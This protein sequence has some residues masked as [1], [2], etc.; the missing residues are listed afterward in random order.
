MNLRQ[1]DTVNVFFILVLAPLFLQNITLLGLGSAGLKVFHLSVA[2]LGAYWLYGLKLNTQLVPALWLLSLW[3]VITFI[4]GLRYGLSPFVLNYIFIFALALVISTQSEMIS[5]HSF[6]KSL[7]WI[8]FPAFLYVFFNILFNLDTVIAAQ[9]FNIRFGGRPIIPNMLFSG[10]WNIEASYLAMLSVLFIRTRWFF[11]FASIAFI[12]SIAYLSRT[13]LVLTVVLGMYWVFFK[14]Y[15]RVSTF[16]LFFLLPLLLLTL[17]IVLLTVG[18]YL[19]VSVVKRLFLIGNEPGSQGRL[20]ILL[21]V[22]PGLLDSQFMGYGPGNTMEKLIAMGLETQNNNL[23]NYYLQVLMDF[24]FLGFV[25]YLLFIVYFILSPHIVL[26]FKLFL[27]LYMVGSFVQFRGAEPLV[28]GILL[29]AFL[30][31]V[32]CQKSTQ[33]TVELPPEKHKMTPQL[34]SGS[35]Q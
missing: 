11:L 35:V 24:G 16:T 1:A 26:E 13:G 18:Y 25:G 2:A 19:D 29:W 6:Q 30:V 17:A 7:L 34:N 12:V 28:W 15:E 9:A 5:F 21:Y 27:S 4:V 14:L 20:D 31:K 3:L 8:V 32:P 22:V 10:G 33:N 23:H